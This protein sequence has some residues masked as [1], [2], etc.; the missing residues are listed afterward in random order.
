MAK[1]LLSKV[2]LATTENIFIKKMEIYIN[3]LLDTLGKWI[4]EKSQFTQ[5][6]AVVDRLLPFSLY[7]K[8]AS[9]QNL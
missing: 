8:T 9:V 2:F 3:L 5:S 6:S 7:H 1:E 4:E